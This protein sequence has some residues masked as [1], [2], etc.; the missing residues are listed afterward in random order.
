MRWAGHAERICNIKMLSEINSMTMTK[1][2]RHELRWE[3]NIKLDLRKYYNC[4]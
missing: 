4:T 1:P 2:Q 3:D